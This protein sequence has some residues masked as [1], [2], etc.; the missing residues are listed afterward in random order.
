[1]TLAGRTPGAPK[2]VAVD[3]LLGGRVLA[4]LTGGD[5]AACWVGT[6]RMPSTNNR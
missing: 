6:T 3:E 1:M 5:L 4:A 2:R